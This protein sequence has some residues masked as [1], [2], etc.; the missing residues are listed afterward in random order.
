MTSDLSLSLSSLPIRYLY[1]RRYFTHVDQTHH[2]HRKFKIVA[3]KIK[4]LWW[5]LP[6]HRDLHGDKV[7][8][9]TPAPSFRHTY[10]SSLIAFSLL[11][12]DVIILLWR[13]WEVCGGGGAEGPERR[14]A[15]HD[16]CFY[17]LAIAIARRDVVM[18]LLR[19]Q[20]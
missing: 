12:D 14:K 16:G 20:T 19:R 2:V 9:R 8:V 15:S 7:G 17:F 18:L 11:S 10:P 3:Y 6:L 13:M 1:R 5:L 4:L